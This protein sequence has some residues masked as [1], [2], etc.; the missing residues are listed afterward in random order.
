MGEYVMM[1]LRLVAGVDSREFNYRFG[2]SFEQLYGGKCEQFIKNGYRTMRGGVY[3]LTPAGM[4]ISNYIL[5]DILEFEDFG[6]YNF[7]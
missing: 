1:R 7:G 3:S 4:F 6:K 5:S 2:R